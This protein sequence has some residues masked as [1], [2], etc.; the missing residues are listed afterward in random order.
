MV[1]A[2][3]ALEVSRTNKRERLLDS[4]SC[5]TEP[6]HWLRQASKRVPKVSY[7]MFF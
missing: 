7:S 5:L 6:S 3:P 2:A 1:L 4:L